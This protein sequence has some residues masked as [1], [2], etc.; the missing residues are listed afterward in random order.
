[1]AMELP[2]RCEPANIQFLWPMATL[3]PDQLPAAEGPLTPEQLPSPAPPL[4]PER[5]PAPELPL[6]PE[7]LPAQE[8]H[9]DFDGDTF[10]RID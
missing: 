8:P 9:I 6:G 7:Q 3:P 10:D 5:L 2:P 4:I 1:M